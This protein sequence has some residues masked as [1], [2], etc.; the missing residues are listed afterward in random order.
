MNTTLP[1]SPCGGEIKT[2]FLLEDV[3]LLHYQTAPVGARSKLKCAVSEE[4]LA[5]T[6]QPLWGRDQNRTQLPPAPR[7]ELP[8]S[9]CG[10]EIKTHAVGTLRDQHHYQTAPAG[11]R[12]K[13]H[14]KNESFWNSCWNLILDSDL[15]DFMFQNLYHKQCIKNKLFY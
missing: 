6:R 15:N 7:R 11:A 3:R 12:S 9:P 4:G 2:E 14:L 10:G 1:D 5:I 13:K 8:D